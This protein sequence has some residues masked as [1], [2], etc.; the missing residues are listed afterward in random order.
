MYRSES[1][2]IYILGNGPLG[3]KGE[4]SLF[5]DRVCDEIGFKIPSPALIVCNDF[6]Q[7]PEQP[8]DRPVFIRGLRTTGENAPFVGLLAA[9]ELAKMRFPAAMRS[10][11]PEI[12]DRL[13][14]TAAGILSTFFFDSYKFET[15]RDPEDSIFYKRTGRFYNS[16]YQPPA[17]AFCDARGFKAIPPLSAVFQPLIGYRVRGKNGLFMTP[18]SGIVNTATENRIKVC[19]VSGF[20]LSAVGSAG[21]GITRVYDEQTNFLSTYGVLTAPLYINMRSGAFEME[22]NEEWRAPSTWIYEHDCPEIPLRLAEIGKRL[23]EKAGS[24][25]DSEWVYRSYDDLYFHQTRPVR[26]KAQSIPRPAPNTEK[27][28]FETCDVLGQNTASVSHVIIRMEGSRFAPKS[29]RKDLQELDKSYPGSLLICTASIGGWSQKSRL[30]YDM[31]ARAKAAIIIDRESIHRSGSGLQH[32]ALTCMDDEKV[33]LYA[34]DSKLIKTIESLGKLI[35]A[36]EEDY[37]AGV[38]VYEMPEPLTISADDENGWGMIWR[39]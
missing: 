5:L 39:D 18:F 35:E 36:R 37:P 33:L 34:R 8:V 17:A 25:M 6:P 3:G 16:A 31:W 32:L 28:F 12:E 2:R 27:V 4:G 26:P 1:G 9:L 11:F 21:L 20:G 29:S 38:Y 22:T 23:S 24:A 13:G 10:S 14:S 15:G 19:T 30:F 7:I